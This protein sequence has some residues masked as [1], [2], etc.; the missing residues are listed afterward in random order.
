MIGEAKWRIHFHDGHMAIQTTIALAGPTQNVLAVEW[1]VAL[2]ALP[3]ATHVLLRD[4]TMGIVTRG[5]GHFRAYKA[6]GLNQPH[7]LKADDGNVL[8]IDFTR[9]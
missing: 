2:N 4:R 8:P 9:V 7:G 5:A 6:L 3:D 1:V